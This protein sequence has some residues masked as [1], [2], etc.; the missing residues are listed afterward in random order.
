MELGY[1]RIG[2]WVIVLKQYKV[3]PTY[4]SSEE[5]INAKMS[6]KNAIC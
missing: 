3:G 4:F 2:N 5:R 6:I 1:E